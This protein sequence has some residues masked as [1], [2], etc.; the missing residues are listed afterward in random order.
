MYTVNNMQ[1]RT[2]LTLKIKLLL[3]SQNDHVMAIKLLLYGQILYLNL[4]YAI[5][6]YIYLQQYIDGKL[7]P[8]DKCSVYNFLRSQ[9]I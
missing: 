2:I 3:N 5:S 7:Y 1:R 6:W 4:F 8:S 9:K